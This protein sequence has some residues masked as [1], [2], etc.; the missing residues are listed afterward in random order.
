LPDQ[1]LIRALVAQPA[2]NAIHDVVV[3]IYGLIKAG[4]FR[5]AALE[6]ILF[7]MFVSGMLSEA[8]PIGE[9]RTFMEGKVL[10][11]DEATLGW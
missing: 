7:V 11:S 2:K 5:A 9:I 4:D 3:R 8:L 6:L 10:A 1:I